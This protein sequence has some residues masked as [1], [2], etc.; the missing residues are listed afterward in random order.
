MANIASGLDLRDENI[1]DSQENRRIQHH[2]KTEGWHYLFWSLLSPI[3]FNFI[4]SNITTSSSLSVPERPS[5]DEKNVQRPTENDVKHFDQEAGAHVHYAERTSPVSQ[6]RRSSTLNDLTPNIPLADTT[7]EDDEIDEDDEYDWSGDEDI[8][9]EQ[10]AY[11]KQIGSGS[12][13]PKKWNLRR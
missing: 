6:K 3:S 12:T 13:T 1:S 10:A 8:A 7:D 9:D 4:D 2:R 5:I 11:E